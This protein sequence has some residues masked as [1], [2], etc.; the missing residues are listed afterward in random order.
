MAKVEKFTTYFCFECG[1]TLNQMICEM[2]GCHYALWTQEEIECVM[3]TH[4]H[5][6]FWHYCGEHIS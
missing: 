6:E 4:S 2:P 3:S 1:T 5:K